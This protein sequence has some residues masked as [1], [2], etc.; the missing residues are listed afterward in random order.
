MTTR[1]LR[2][3][4]FDET[5]RTDGEGWQWR[6]LAEVVVEMP[7]GFECP[8]ERLIESA[9]MAYRHVMGADLPKLE[10]PE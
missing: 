8:G 3:E 7:T 10:V 5:E 6:T 4:V 1:K 9:R 2:I